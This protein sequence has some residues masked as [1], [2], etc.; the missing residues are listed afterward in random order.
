[1]VFLFKLLFFAIS[2][3]LVTAD[4][5]GDLSPSE[6]TSLQSLFDSTDGP[7]WR[8]NRTEPLST[9]WTFPVI[10]LDVPCV[11]SWQ[12]VTCSN[13]AVSGCTVTEL[14]L[15]GRNLNGVI[16]SQ[17]TG[18]TGLVQLSFLLN[19][20]RGKIPSQIGNLTSLE[21][22][23][24][25]SN[26]LTGTLPSELGLLTSMNVLELS[27]NSFSGSIPSELSNLKSMTQLLL[28]SN[29]LTAVIPSDLSQLTSLTDMYL[30]SNSLTGTIPSELGVLTSLSILALYSNC[31]TGSIPA[32]LGNLTALSVLSLYTTRLTGTIPTEL[33]WLTSITKLYLYN[34]S[35]TGPIPSQFG[36]FDSLTELALNTNYLTGTIPPVLGLLTSITTLSLYSNSLTGTIPSNIRSL[37]M[38][39]L[40]LYENSLTGTIPSELGRL[41]SMKEMT[42]YANNL[43]G[44]ISSELGNL[45]TMTEFVLYLNSLTGSIPS[46]LGG[47][48]S[49]TGLFL[50]SNYLTGSIPSEICLISSLSELS[51][52]SNS[53][54]GVIPSQLGTL[55]SLSEIALYSNS[56]TGSI[57]SEIG[58]LT[59]LT[60]LSVYSN[61]LTGTFPSDLHNSTLAILGPQSRLIDFNI[62]DNF[63]SGLM[64]SFNSSLQVFDI[65]SNVFSG[66]VP[67]F[68]GP[69][70]VSFN[71]SVNTFVDSIPS[72]LCRCV[73]IRSID[74][75][76]NDLYGQLPSCLSS[77]PLLEELVAS[78]NRLDGSLD[79]LE[80]QR[81]ANASLPDLSVLDLSFN[82]FTG[83][84]PDF[85]FGLRSLSS[86][87]LSSNCFHGPLS[88]GICNAYN[89]TEI[90]MDGLSSSSACT[91]D[92]F[93]PLLQGVF[94][95]WFISGSIPEC[96]WSSMPQVSTLHMSGNGLVGTLGRLSSFGLSDLNLA[97]NRLS[98]T[99]PSSFQHY[100]NFDKLD[101]SNNKLSGTLSSSF[102][103]S[104]SQL[105]LNMSLNRLSGDIPSSFMHAPGVSVLN[106]NLFACANG[107]LPDSDSED[108]K[109]TCGSDELNYSIL[110]WLCGVGIFLIAVCLSGEIGGLLTR[111]D[112]LNTSLRV[113]VRCSVKV[114][115]VVSVGASVVYVSM[116]LG[117]WQNLYSTHIHQYGWVDSAVYLRGAVPA[118]CILLMLSGCV[119]L[120]FVP[121]LRLT[122]TS[123]KEEGGQ[124]ASRGRSAYVRIVLSHSFNLCIVLLVNVV[125]IYVSLQRISADK[126]LMV[127]FVLSVFKVAWKSLAIP[128]LCAWSESDLFHGI[129]MT[130]VAFVLGPI[131]SA[132]FSQ[133]SCFLYALTGQPSVQSTFNLE[134]YVCDPVERT[135]CLDT[136]C[137]GTYDVTC[138]FDGYS[139]VSI[140][141]NMGW[142]YS[143]QC[144]S[145]F[146]IDY[147]PVFILAS[148]ISTVV[149][150][151]LVW[152]QSKF[153][154]PPSSSAA[155]DKLSVMSAISKVFLNLTVLLTF[156]LADPLLAVTVG[157]DCFMQAS[158][159]RVKDS[160][161][162]RAVSAEVG[163][164]MISML[165]F[166]S[167]VI[168]LFW[169]LFVLDMIGDQYGGVA[170]GCCMLV[171][172]IGS[173][174]LLEC[175]RRRA[176]ASKSD[177]NK[178]DSKN[179]VIVSPIYQSPDIYQ[180]F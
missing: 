162:D 52:F 6:L 39:V 19:R 105:M 153:M 36:A 173:L 106:G 12:G 76:D 110:A 78:N 146:L 154:P 95:K 22:L 18:L 107:Q 108:S 131:V 96:I 79:C 49:L 53:L 125:Y 84:I 68:Y 77:L 156:G 85:I 20:L 4:C 97:H 17:I 102:L 33:G 44:T 178:K 45:A 112:G 69:D 158:R 171:P 26:S 99:I 155:L 166:V 9:H 175:S 41:T 116:K 62:G 165:R 128:M 59:A 24:L 109:Y 169:S 31:L 88:A 13:S 83:T 132:F 38:T 120:S 147:A 1:M 37:N 179:I 164:T 170:G 117:P 160:Y 5:V 129:A 2:A 81:G 148:L 74:V 35:L 90:I 8:W 60:V 21:S 172:V 152:L 124:E 126:L 7:N 82:H 100:G 121:L 93:K 57:P 63:L 103:V 80:P 115:C 134:Q 119:W 122:V 46:E 130:V 98:G 104:N 47:L 176:C 149:V 137:Y 161:D 48:S 28:E 65:S 168:G 174:V 30:Y 51:L 58:Q 75:S 34:S 27:S 157:L 67:A 56:L 127:Q 10:K 3:F 32:E 11:D 118:C 113:L 72:S 91:L 73:K 66:L 167:V 40:F 55:A 143:Y 71:I 86:L 43:T 16:P 101:L 50:E 61:S 142:I 177:M 70:L 15:Q 159:L 114:A 139:S 42:L 180:A 151:V 135:V 29:S 123:E 89:A 136:N 150:P 64:P 92:S 14:V 94:P 141:I 133:S 138:G 111:M 23:D 145:A 144:S 54:T 163:R 87:I 25:K 140:N